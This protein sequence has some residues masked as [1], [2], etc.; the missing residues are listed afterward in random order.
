MNLQSPIE[1]LDI[2]LDEELQF[3]SE[4]LYATPRL[5]INETDF[6]I[7]IEGVAKFGVKNGRTVSVLPHQDAD[8]ASVQLF[9]NGSV[10][11]ALLHQRGVLPL[12]GSSF[13]LNGKGIIICGCSGV[14]KSSVTAAFCK[15]GASFI[16]DDITP[17]VAEESGITKIIPIKTQIKLWNDTLKAF[18]I[19]EDGLSR[20]RP[21]LKKY[22]LPWE[23]YNGFQRLN[24]II[25]LRTYEK[26][27]YEAEELKGMAKYNA[28]RRNIYRKLYLRGMPETARNIFKH[29][30]KIAEDIDVIVVSRP[31]IS[32]INATMEFILKQL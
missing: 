25:I 31:K 19:E 21:S 23:K 24:K 30:L 26:R 8:E 27:H 7:T 4:P 20:I 13:V 3:S 2:V 28:L 16:N 18:G 11:G 15:R 1:S 12:H 29:L 22:Y 5:K 14:G 6:E 9:L 32:D 10:L 17:V